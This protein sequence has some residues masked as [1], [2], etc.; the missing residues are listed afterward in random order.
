MV[1]GQGRKV[2]ARP[3]LDSC[4]PMMVGGKAHCRESESHGSEEGRKVVTAG[5]ER[6]RVSWDGKGLGKEYEL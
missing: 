2:P 6:E 5:R 3:G 4:S 1:S